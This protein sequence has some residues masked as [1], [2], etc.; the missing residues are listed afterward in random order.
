MGVTLTQEMING[1]I[2]AQE[3]YGVPASVTLAQIMQERNCV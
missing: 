3:K 2:Q 1:A